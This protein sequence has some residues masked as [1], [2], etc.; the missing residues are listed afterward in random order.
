MLS[1]SDGWRKISLTEEQISKNKSIL[2]SVPTFAENIRSIFENRE[3]YK[4]T[5]DPETRL[6]DSFVPEVDK[7]RIEAVRNAKPRELADFHPNFVDERLAPLLLHYKARNYPETLAEEEVVL[8]EKWRSQK[9]SLAL[10][11]FMKSI[12]KI[13]SETTDD[14]KIFILQELQLWAESIAPIDLEN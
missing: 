13:A 12:Q 1:Q 7:I 2:L 10:P 6:Y 9:I 3:D 8:W 4:K 11:G 14:S 5:T